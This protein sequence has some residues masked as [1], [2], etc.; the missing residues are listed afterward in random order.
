MIACIIK[1]H[2]KQTVKS[3]KKKL[4]ILLQRLRFMSDVVNL[5][6]SNKMKILIKEIKKQTTVQ[7]SK[8]IQQNAVTPT[9]SFDRKC[10]NTQ[11]KITLVK[12]FHG[13]HT[14]SMGM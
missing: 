4:Y 8:L 9:N 6:T 12:P 7:L 3:Q 1:S 11:K 13:L 2:S 10:I 5:L 14:Q